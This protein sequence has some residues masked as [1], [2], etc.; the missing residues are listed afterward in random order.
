MDSLGEA[1]NVG[2]MAQSALPVFYDF[3]FSKTHAPD[4][5]STNPV[6][7]TRVLEAMSSGMV[8]TGRP[9][10]LVTFS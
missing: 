9:S 10:W 2:G 7:V 8:K 6:A 3:D 1:A 4:H 5:F